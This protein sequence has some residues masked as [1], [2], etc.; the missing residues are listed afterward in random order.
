MSYM[1][2]GEELF[3]NFIVFLFV[4]YHIYVI[5]LL[6]ARSFPRINIYL[7]TCSVSLF[8]LTHSRE[9]WCGVFCCMCGRSLFMAPR[10]QKSLLKR[11]EGRL[12]L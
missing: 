9:H 8:F 3:N 4:G 10:L 6:A 2:D 7:L 5:R 12:T 1:W 11:V